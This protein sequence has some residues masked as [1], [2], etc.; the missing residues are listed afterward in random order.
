MGVVGLYEMIDALVVPGMLEIQDSHI[1][2]QFPTFKAGINGKRWAALQEQVD[3]DTYITLDCHQHPSLPDGTFKGHEQ[4][5]SHTHSTTP[6]G[7]DVIS[8]AELSRCT[9]Q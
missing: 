7:R 4:L 3:Q 2:F 9:Q 8:M 5:V 6:D 1:V